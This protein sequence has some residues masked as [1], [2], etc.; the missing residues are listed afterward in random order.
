MSDHLFDRP[1]ALR[2]EAIRWAIAETGADA[3]HHHMLVRGRDQI[4]RFHGVRGIGAPPAAEERWR[5]SEGLAAVLAESDPDHVAPLNIL[6]DPPEDFYL[7]R[8][9]RFSFA[10]VGY[11][12]A[13]HINVTDGIE[14]RG[15]VSLVR[16]SAAP[17]VVADAVRERVA[18]RL[19]DAF[20]TAWGMEVVLAAPEGVVEVR[21]D[22]TASADESV[23]GWLAA[24]GASDWLRARASCF[25]RKEGTVFGRSDRA[26]MPGAFVHG[27]AMPGG[28]MLYEFEPVAPM[29]LPPVLA[30]LTP[31]QR[32][33]A[34]LAAAGATAVEIAR[35]LERSPET[36]REHLTRIY[37][38]LGLA[39]RSELATACRRM[40]I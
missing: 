40:M 2:A 25:L 17:W 6:G 9:W 33:I 36:V 13:I 28:G 38:R 5:V 19:R 14:V 10:E 35:D 27:R 18:A 29:E 16:V 22:G 15:H 34:S 12:R 24:H 1:H 26:W 8:L 37:D 21:P 32:R 11:R 23:C 4:V 3:G 31:L 20:R 30:R 39:S 7:S